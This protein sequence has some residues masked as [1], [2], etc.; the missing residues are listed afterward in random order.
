MYASIQSRKRKHSKYYKEHKKDHLVDWARKTNNELIEKSTIYEKDL[1]HRLKSRFPR[2]VKSQLPFLI[3][4][5]LY[6]AD[7]SIPSVKLIIEVDG[8]YHSKPEQ[9]AKDKKRDEDFKSIGYTTLRYTN[10]QVANSECRK[11]I[12]QKILSYKS[13]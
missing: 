9:Q 10:E 3:N 11:N 12:V 4:G 7:I 5:K 8:G 1:L 6:Y 2:L 13:K